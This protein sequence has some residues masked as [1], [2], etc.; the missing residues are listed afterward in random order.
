MRRKDIEL[1]NETTQYFTVNGAVDEALKLSVAVDID[2]EHLE[3][4][5]F[6]KD[7]AEQ[8]QENR[9]PSFAFFSFNRYHRNA[10][11]DFDGEE[12]GV[13]GV[14]WLP[15]SYFEHGFCH[16]FPADAP[17]PAGVE[18]RWDGV[19]T[20]GIAVPAEE[21]VEYYDRDPKRL[22]EAC[23]DACER[24]TAWCNGIGYY[25]DVQYATTSGVKAESC[26]GF[27]GDDMETNGLSECL[28]DALKG[29]GVKQ[30]MNWIM[31]KHCFITSITRI[32]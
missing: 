15:L 19:R 22:L 5:F 1:N 14:D 26:G 3:E 20:A 28:Q 12:F 2:I 21:V 23:A 25:Y 27:L 30:L 8:K 16:W 4:E 17:A 31:P 6:V 29:F 10:L 13:E 7:P 32:N 18:M 9:I 24:F 11:L